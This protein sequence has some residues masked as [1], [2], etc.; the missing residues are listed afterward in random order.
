M[1]HASAIKSTRS[2]RWACALALYAYTAGDAAYI[3][4]QCDKLKKKAL[5][6]PN[7][8]LPPHEAGGAPPPTDGGG[9]SRP[10][11]H[12]NAPARLRHAATFPSA[13]D[14]SMDVNAVVE[15]MTSA[16]VRR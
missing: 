11:R 15:D 13:A 6:A 16:G 12:E 3:Q 4:V 14:D 2:S 5:L 10:A 8:A 1:A 7:A 9:Q